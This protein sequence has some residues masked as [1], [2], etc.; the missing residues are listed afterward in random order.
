M[1]MYRGG[2]G[3]IEEI[4]IAKST[5]KFVVFENGR[6]D[7][8]DSSYYCYRES[9]E[10]VKAVMINRV[11]ADIVRLESALIYNKG[12]LERVKAL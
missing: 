4:E 9:K 5:N 7:S 1:K 12:R 6:K 11:L 8:K 10:E 2:C 3:K